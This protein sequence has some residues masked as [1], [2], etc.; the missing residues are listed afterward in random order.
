MSHSETEPGSN[1]E[2][3]ELEEALSAGALT[4]LPPNRP[5]GILG[6]YGPSLRTVDTFEPDLNAGVSQENDGPVI[7]LAIILAFLLFFP[8]G[9][10][11][12]W[13]S[14]AYSRRGKFILT[15]VATFIIA[16][17]AWRLVGAR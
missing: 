6:E 8:A 7:Q 15:V 5:R 9:Y 3:P 12:L 1:A 13:R 4:E 16:A 10:W 14:S 11:L 17:V 2:S